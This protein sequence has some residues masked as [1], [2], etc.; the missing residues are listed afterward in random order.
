MSHQRP[1]HEHAFVERHVG[2]SAAQQRAMLD[3]V[4][5]DTL[6]DLVRAAVPAS[7]L[8]PGE[9]GEDPEG[10]R[11]PEEPGLAD[12]ASEADVLAWPFGIHDPGLEAAAMA[13]GYRASLALGERRARD[14]DP[15]QALPRFLIADATGV[16]GLANLIRKS[17]E[18]SK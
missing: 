12:P 1:A 3:V 10:L 15:P 18:T 5:H 16:N 6:A 9:E 13:A 11:E 7:V 4:G 17:G 2:T 8:S 14:T